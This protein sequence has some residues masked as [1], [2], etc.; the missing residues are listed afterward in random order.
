VTPSAQLSGV[1]PIYRNHSLLLCA[2]IGPVIALGCA[3]PVATSQTAPP[4]AQGTKT[5]MKKPNPPQSSP[6]VS[7]P[8]EAPSPEVSAPLDM[9]PMQYSEGA[10]AQMT[11]IYARAEEIVTEVEK[12][13]AVAKLDD[14]AEW[15]RHLAALR[16]AAM[17]LGGD[18]FHDGALG[19]GTAALNP[20]P[21][22]Q[23][24]RE[25]YRF[26]EASHPLPEDPLQRL[27]LM[28]KIARAA[29]FDEVVVRSDG[30]VD[31]R[32]LDR[33]DE[34]RRAVEER[35]SKDLDLEVLTD[36]P[37][38]LDK[39]VG[40]AVPRIETKE[41]SLTVFGPPALLNIVAQEMAGDGDG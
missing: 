11:Q 5:P 24:I 19:P 1:K 18:C 40:D 35:N 7:A 12:E 31:G 39:W 6:E 33:A 23:R 3:T 26:A 17:Q 20:G 8:L 30:W 41:R 34:L 32:G 25:A 28:L 37:P 36:V 29:G 38:D 21:Y 4:G 13:A 14:T 15:P 16:A 2:L 27:D 10:G 22:L 9:P